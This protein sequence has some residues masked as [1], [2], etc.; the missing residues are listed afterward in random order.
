M[1]DV[2]SQFIDR[3]KAESDFIKLED[4][5]SIK[6]KRLL[7]IN[8]VDTIG[9]DKR[10]KTVLRFSCLVDTMLGERTKNFDNGTRKFVEA[11]QQ[12]GVKIGSAFTITRHG[13]QQS[14]VYFIS[15]VVAP[16]Q[17]GQAFTGKQAD[18]KPLP[19]M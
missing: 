14:T 16:T 4:G 9:F 7:D 6:V 19:P 17:A 10:P 13:V 18:E 2:L 8:S 12:K 5:E 1:S 15:D 11:V 3:K